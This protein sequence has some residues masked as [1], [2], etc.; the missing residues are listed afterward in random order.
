MRVGLF[1]PVTF[2]PFPETQLRQ[3][4]ARAKVVLVPEMNTGQ[5]QFI[6]EGALG[7]PVE[8]MHLFSGEVIAPADIAA[9]AAALVKE[10]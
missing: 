9:R 7:K 1:R 5:L 2:W 10:T 3:A 8:G 6:V 4:A